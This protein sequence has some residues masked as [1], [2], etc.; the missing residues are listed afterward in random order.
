MPEALPQFESRLD[1]G[2]EVHVGRRVQIK[3]EATRLLGVARLTV[4]R[5]QLQ[6]RDLRHGD[7]AFDVVDLEIGLV[8]PAYLDERQQV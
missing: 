5:M 7:E 6:G 4:P 8:I 3:H 2:F 1:H